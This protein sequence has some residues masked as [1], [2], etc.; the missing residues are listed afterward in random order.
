MARKLRASAAGVSEHVIQRGNNRQVVF[1]N[2][3]DMKAY[4]TWLKQYAK[5]YKVSIHAWVLMTNHVHLLCTPST[6]TGI[7]QMMQ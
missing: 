7:S 4:V 1:C 2:K 3:D 5:K 6:A